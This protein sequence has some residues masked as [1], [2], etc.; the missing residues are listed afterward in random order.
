M[1]APSAHSADAND[2]INPTGTPDD[3]NKL[4]S[5]NLLASSASPAD[6]SA[7]DDSH[8][9]DKLESPNLLASND[10]PASDSA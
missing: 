10:S 9:S 2:S 8:A 7:A 3:K 4:E 1:Y 5:P 6:L